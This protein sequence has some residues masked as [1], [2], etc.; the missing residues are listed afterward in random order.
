M[1]SGLCLFVA[2]SYYW[3][4]LTALKVGVGWGAAVF[5]GNYLAAL[6]FLLC[7]PAKAARPVLLHTL[8]WVFLLGYGFHVLH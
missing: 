4:L 6:L 5:F 2:G 1:I 3:V 7:H 8:S